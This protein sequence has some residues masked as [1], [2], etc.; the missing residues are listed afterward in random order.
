MALLEVATVLAILCCSVS[1]ASSKCSHGAVCPSGDA[2]T[3]MQ[4]KKN[5]KLGSE[6]AEKQESAGAGGEVQHNLNGAADNDTLEEFLSDG[7]QSSATTQREQCK[8]PLCNVCFQLQGWSRILERSREVKRMEFLRAKKFNKYGVID[9]KGQP[10][11]VPF[12]EEVPEWMEEQRN[13]DL[14]SRYDD[15]GRS[16]VG[17]SSQMSE[18]PDWKCFQYDEEGH[19]PIVEAGSRRRNMC[20][21]RYTPQNQDEPAIKCERFTKSEFIGI[22]SDIASRKYRKMCESCKCRRWFYGFG[23]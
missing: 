4:V 1:A 17:S 8:S 3:L 22:S 13:K 18:D 10:I 2:T 7:S 12:L 23:L 20:I 21:E 5:I 9:P 14:W 16:L 6:R 19:N 11:P 15:R